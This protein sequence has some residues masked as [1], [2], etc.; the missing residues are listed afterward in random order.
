MLHK[1]NNQEVRGKKSIAEYLLPLSSQ[2]LV[3]TVQYLND[4]IGLI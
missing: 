2:G 3:K 4:N 1:I